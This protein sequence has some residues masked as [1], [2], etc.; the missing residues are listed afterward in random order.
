MFRRMEEHLLVSRERVA[1]GA[2]LE[3]ADTPECETSA[4]ACLAFAVELCVP[5][6]GVTRI[7]DKAHGLFW[8]GPFS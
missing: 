1:A 2:R 3:S 6:I 7:C 8:R 5:R 4:E